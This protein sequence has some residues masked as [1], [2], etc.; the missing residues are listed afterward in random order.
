MTLSA[1]SLLGL[2][3]STSDDETRTL[4]FPLDT[5]IRVLVVS[6]GVAGT[7][8]LTTSGL[9]SDVRDILTQ[10]QSE[11][12]K[13]TLQEKLVDERMSTMR[14]TVNDLKRRLELTQYELSAVKELVIKLPNQK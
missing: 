1:P 7:F 3:M 9:R 10:M 4:T 8:W 2:I 14:E 12:E 13:R 6:I 11:S 5:V